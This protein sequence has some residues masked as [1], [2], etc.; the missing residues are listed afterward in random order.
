LTT[1]SV[2]VL[3]TLTA[4]VT[5]VPL[6]TVQG[7]SSVNVL[8][9]PTVN[10]TNVPAVNITS[11]IP[12]FQ[13]S[14]PFVD[15]TAAHRDDAVTQSFYSASCP[16]DGQRLGQRV[17]TG[18]GLLQLPDRHYF[19]PSRI[20]YSLLRRPIVSSV[21]VRGDRLDSR[22]DERHHDCTGGDA[23]HDGR[24]GFGRAA[25]RS[26]GLER[27]IVERLRQVHQRKHRGDSDS[28]DGA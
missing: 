25:L 16:M 4:N 3:N 18:G 17:V 5:N 2:N 26:P 23:E 27:R 12:F 21:V 14:A 9:A 24:Q 22:R 20:E 1:T 13:S 15:G 10:V 6:V 8:N 7:T 19:D 11:S 28:F